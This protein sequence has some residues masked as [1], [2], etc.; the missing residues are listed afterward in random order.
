MYV[1][2]LLR[3]DGRE[4]WSLLGCRGGHLY[5]CG[6]TAMGREVVLALQ[7]TAVEHGKLSEAEP[8]LFE[9]AVT[10]RE[11]LG[12]DH[13]HSKIFA[14]NLNGVRRQ[15][16]TQSHAIFTQPTENEEPRTFR[17]KTVQMRRGLGNATVR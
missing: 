10:A 4:V 12:A 8:L 11:V 14:R 1:Q 6:G 9:C 16:Q 13:P 17:Q 3:E 7:R 15:T 2:D 5:I